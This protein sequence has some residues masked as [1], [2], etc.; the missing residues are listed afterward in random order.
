[1]KK[2]LYSTTALVGAALLFGDIST[3][4]ADVM[5][6]T[7]ITLGASTRFQLMSSSID[8][9][10]KSALGDGGAD[11]KQIRSA[12]SESRVRLA[13]DGKREHPNGLTTGFTL[14]FKPTEGSTV[15][16]AFGYIQGTFGKIQLGN[17]QSADNQLGFVPIHYATG[18]GAIDADVPSMAIASPGKGA[19]VG[20]PFGR[21]GSGRAA[22]IAYFSPSVSGFQMGVSYGAED[23]KANKGG[24]GEEVAGDVTDSFGVGFNY[25]SSYNDV[26]VKVG[27]GYSTGSYSKKD[28]ATPFGTAALSVAE[29]GAIFASDGADDNPDVALR[30]EA[31]T[32]SVTPDYTAVPDKVGDDPATFAGAVSFSFADLEFGATWSSGDFIDGGD[33]TIYGLGGSYSMDAF[34]FGLS[35][36]NQQID[37]PGYSIN[38]A[39]AVTFLPT[40]GDKFEADTIAFT[41]GYGVGDG[42]NLGFVIERTDWTHTRFTYEGAAGSETFA[43]RTLE[44]SRTGFGIGLDLSF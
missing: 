8:D 9:D 24:N 27:A 44:D 34:T 20:Y 16:N 1:M 31:P 40:G 23:N 7:E 12:V 32:G 39:G 33:G 11:G 4:K 36:G 10:R 28:A 17:Q 43:D 29:L 30:G 22:R 13:L 41:V 14:R 6:D 21:S 15:D 3:A 5:S 19:T 26:G 38:S 42:A 18:F 25:E 35:W 2:F 37:N